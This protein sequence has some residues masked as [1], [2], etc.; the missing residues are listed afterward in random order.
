MI[1]FNTMDSNTVGDF[2]YTLSATQFD[3]FLYDEFTIEPPGITPAPPAGFCAVSG[4]VLTAGNTIPSNCRVT[5]RPLQFPLS[6][7]N[8]VVT[9]DAIVTYPDIN[10]NFT[11]NLVQGVTMVVEIQRTGIRAQITIPM[12]SSATLASLLPA[13]PYPPS[14]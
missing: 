2:F 5:F 1:R 14:N 3:N 13:F 12:T 6:V 4:N 11:V 9:A 8:S 10:G 7:G